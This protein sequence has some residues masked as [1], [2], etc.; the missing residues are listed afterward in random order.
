[1]NPY[2]GD[3]K[4]DPDNEPECDWCDNYRI[5]LDADENAAPCPYCQHDPDPGEPNEDPE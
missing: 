3:R 1:M 4:L 2:I 5:M